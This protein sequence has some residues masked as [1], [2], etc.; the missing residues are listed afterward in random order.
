MPFVFV[1]S[2]RFCPTLEALRE[3]DGTEKIKRIVDCRR[4][5]QAQFFALRTPN[6]DTQLYLYGNTMFYVNEKL[7]SMPDAVDR[8]VIHRRPI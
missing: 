2:T 8:V 3:N 4:E 7:P 6:V 5:C 1:S